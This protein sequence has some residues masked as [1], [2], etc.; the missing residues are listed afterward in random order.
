MFGK[1]VLF[2]VS[3]TAVPALG[4]FASN[5][6]KNRLVEVN[7]FDTISGLAAVC[8][9]PGNESHPV[10]EA[11]G[12]MDFLSDA[13]SIALAVSL[14][15]PLLY[16]L[17]AYALARDRNLLARFFPMLVRVMLGL[18]PV[19]LLSHGLLL[20]F[21]TWE[22][23]QVGLVP[24]NIRI[25]AVPA[26]LGGT[27]ILTAI[28]IVSDLR[29]MLEIDPLRITGVVVE[30]AEMPA[31][32]DRI[33]RIA[34]KLGSVAPSR[35]IVGIEPN[36]FV[37]DTVIRLRGVG[38]LPG[39]ETL[40]LP[41]FALRLL[42]DAE[43]DAVIGHELGHFR[44][45]DLEFSRR[46]APAFRSLQIA[47]E[48]VHAH[49]S[50]EPD[51]ASLAMIP[52][53]GF[54][55]FMLHTLGRI[56]SGINRER[57]FAADRAALEV[58]TPVAI[59]SLLVKFTLMSIRWEAFH[60]G[61][62]QLLHRGVSRKNM[63]LDYLAHVRGFLG[64]IEPD[65]LSRGLL[66]SHTPHPLD[67]HPTSAQRAAAVGV[68]LAAVIG[69]SLEQLRVDRPDPPGLL[70]IEERLSQIDAD[71]YRHPAQPVVVDDDPALP[72]ELRFRTG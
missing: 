10:C 1:I 65:K 6:G 22:G 7:H 32:F 25:I 40:Y 12:T 36:A 66:A 20:W 68:D 43:L 53:V 33:A 28:G 38:D 31:L 39:A 54:L 35:L 14:G 48:S 27:L 26:I 47:T 24:E 58:S 4:L 13:S 41:S 55:A 59:T 15:L 21:A 18:L 9:R 42:D 2:I 46:F 34:Q 67:S 64:A 52:A 16:L 45:A 60:R 3:L 8:A 30:R 23:M 56:V 51:A 61:T 49:A 63:G 70:A 62:S 5:Y 29:R 37:A 11:L 57:E 72:H 17:A 71:Y 50:E 19:L 44:G 69:P